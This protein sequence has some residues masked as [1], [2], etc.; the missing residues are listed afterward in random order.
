[1]LSALPRVSICLTRVRPLTAAPLARL[2]LPRRNALPRD[3]PG[4][5]P[6]S[7]FSIAPSV[8]SRGNRPAAPLRP[9]CSHTLTL[10]RPP[11]GGA[12][13]HHGPRFARGA[14]R[15]ALPRGCCGGSLALA[16]LTAPGP[17]R[18][19]AAARH[20]ACWITAQASAGSAGAVPL[21]LIARQGKRSKAAPFSPFTSWAAVLA[22]K[23]SLAPEVP[24]LT[25]P[26]RRRGTYS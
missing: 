22:V 4:C 2:A 15:S 26:V 18:G 21:S 20:R 16:S 25:A 23:G 13:P 19:V 6:R 24:P 7:H 12:A 8:P 10:M 5:S 1:V 17:S 3:Y 9:R 11:T 14:G